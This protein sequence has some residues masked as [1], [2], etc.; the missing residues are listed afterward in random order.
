MSA[1]LKMLIISLSMNM[2]LAIAGFSLGGFDI[3]GQYVSYNN[4]TG[5][6]GVTSSYSI[7]SNQ[8]NLPL[9]LA[10]GSIGTGVQGFSFIDGLKM[11]FNFII[12]MIVSLFMPVY[13]L[14][15]FPFP[16]WLGMIIVMM[17]IIG[18][19]ALILTAVRGVPQ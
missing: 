8:T 17:Q 4:T 6:T 3:F 10:T 1:V 15:V 11:S 13:W 12:M 14:L 2:F 9:T 19:A 16:M 7:T 5:I 18:I